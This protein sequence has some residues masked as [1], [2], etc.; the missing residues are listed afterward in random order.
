M[1]DQQ[2]TNTTDASAR[3][4]LSA[5][6]WWWLNS[7]ATPTFILLAGLLIIFAMGVAQRTGW[8]SAGENPQQVTGN[9]DAQIHTCPMHPQIRQPGIGRCPIC[10][11]ALV[12]ATASGGADLEIRNSKKSLD[13]SLFERQVL[14][15]GE[16][17]GALSNG[18]DAL[19]DP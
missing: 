13:R 15:I 17:H 9:S 11:M 18:G 19:A 1:T 6:M 16:G 3:K 8:I 4:P 5:K 10:G 12:P 2:Q 7:L 14:N